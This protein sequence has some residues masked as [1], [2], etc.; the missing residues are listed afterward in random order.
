MRTRSRP[1]KKVRNG[2]MADIGLSL[3]DDGLFTSSAED[4]L[5]VNPGPSSVVC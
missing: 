3:V 5:V 2:P 4:L 1:G